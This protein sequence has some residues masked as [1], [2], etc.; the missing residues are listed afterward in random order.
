MNEKFI[1]RLIELI[2][3][4]PELRLA[5]LEAINS[6]SKAQTALA[7]WRNRRK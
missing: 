3:E 2:K 7:S 4:D 1:L 6:Y 5:L